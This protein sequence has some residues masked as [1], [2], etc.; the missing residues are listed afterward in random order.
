MRPIV[1]PLL[2]I[3]ASLPIL[4]SD[5]LGVSHITGQVLIGSGQ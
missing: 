1:L 4:V 2:N 5:M 3:M